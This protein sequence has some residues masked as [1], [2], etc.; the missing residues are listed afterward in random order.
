MEQSL[1]EYLVT[2][3]QLGIQVWMLGYDNF[4]AL[5]GNQRPD[6]AE[7][8]SAVYLTAMLSHLANVTII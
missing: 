3:F 8:K 6:G 4:H 1:I 2:Y 5:S 7:L